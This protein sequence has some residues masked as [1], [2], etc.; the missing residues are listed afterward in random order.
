[1]SSYLFLEI[2]LVLFVA[3]LT[4]GRV[5]WSLLFSKWFLRRA[6][7]L[8]VIWFAIDQAA[9]TLGLWYFPQGGTLP[10]RLLHLPIEEYLLFGICT[11]ICALL[12]SFFLQ[13]EQA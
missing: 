1:M 13:Q 4:H 8:F 2:S 12:V 9:V 5:K 6:I 3:V 10:F 11:G 7:L